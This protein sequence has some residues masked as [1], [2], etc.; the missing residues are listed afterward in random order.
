M[1]VNTL[2][3]L[4]T[5]NVWN[6]L[7]IVVQQSVSQSPSVSI[8]ILCRYLY[9][10]PVI[11]FTTAR[12]ANSDSA[13][14]NG[15]PTLFLLATITSSRPCGSFRMINAWPRLTY[16]PLSVVRQ[17]ASDPLILSFFGLE[18]EAGIFTVMCYSAD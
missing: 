10:S 11:D 8:S 18:R 12:T 6:L 5:S 2:P 9:G 1:T 3:F 16:F 4:L 15:A 7:Y 17:S 14:W 13:Y